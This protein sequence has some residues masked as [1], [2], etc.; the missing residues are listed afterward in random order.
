MDLIVI[1]L[2]GNALLA[3][4][5]KQSFSRE[6]R[7]VDRVS[8][9][10]ARLCKRSNYNVVVT[11]G[12]GSQVG[13]ELLRNEHAKSYVPKLPLYVLNAETQAQIGAVV[14][15][16]LANSLGSAGVRRDVCVILAHVL[17][18]E[19]DPAFMKPSKPIGPYYTENE[20][21]V[22]LKFGRFSY[23]KLDGGYRK[24]VASPA[25]KEIIEIGAIR[26]EVEKGIIITCG[27]GG[28]PVVRRHG[29]ISGID[30]VID[31]DLTTQLLAT[32]IG[33]EKIVILTDADYVYS[34]HQKRRGPIREIKAK[35]LKKRLKTFEEGTI[36]PKIDA[37]IRFIE[38]GG[39]DA[40][41][42]NVFELEDILKGKVGTR[43]Y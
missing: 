9:S 18:D 39:K 28:V 12:N 36:R 14:E 20:L 2:G 10:I 30:A 17:V 5:G 4:S 33:A 34:D 43:I 15:T 1:A 16:S 22:E 19:K 29:K 37:C 35:D 32:R 25:P 23:T 41:I 21:Q 31:K 6:N 24:V 3:P 27:G 40:Y 11:H 13:D 8:K 26:R 38:N 7:N 42:G